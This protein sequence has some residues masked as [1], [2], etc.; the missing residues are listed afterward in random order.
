MYIYLHPVTQKH[1]HVWRQPSMCADDY[2]LIN[3]VHLGCDSFLHFKRQ[4]RA[5]L[6]HARRAS[7]HSFRLAFTPPTM[8]ID[9]YS[10]TVCERCVLQQCLYTVY[11]EYTRTPTGNAMLLVL[12]HVR[13]AHTLVGCVMRY[14]AKTRARRTAAG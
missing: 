5:Q 14:T 7:S 1:K 8:Y 4:C 13:A 10:R 6:P 12:F 9:T 2:Y 11:G 3:D